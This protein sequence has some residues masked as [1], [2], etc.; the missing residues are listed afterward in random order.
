MNLPLHAN[1]HDLEM[2]KLPSDVI[3][4]EL[5]EYPPHLHEKSREDSSYLW[6]AG[7]FALTGTGACIHA[8]AMVFKAINDPD[9]YVNFLLI[10][11]GFWLSSAIYGVVLNVY[12]Y[13]NIKNT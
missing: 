10:G 9:P 7:A 3:R 5:S 6:N 12:R 4:K 1:G 8:T 13:Y 2:G 11:D